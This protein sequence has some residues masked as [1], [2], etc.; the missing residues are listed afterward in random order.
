M[1]KKRETEDQSSR[2][3]GRPAKYPPLGTIPVTPER[4]AKALMR[5]PP[6][7]LLKRKELTSP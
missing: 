6:R 5:R 3:V 2:P 4:L 7:K 1:K